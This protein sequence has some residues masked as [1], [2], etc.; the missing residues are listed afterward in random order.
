MQNDDFHDEIKRQSENILSKKEIIPESKPSSIGEKINCA[1]KPFKIDLKNT[2][3]ASFP[4][5]TN[6]PNNIEEEKSGNKMLFPEI[7]LS[8]K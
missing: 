3:I 5:L 8:I 7:D 1:I 4:K 2:E 6:L